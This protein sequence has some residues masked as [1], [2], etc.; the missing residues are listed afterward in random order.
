MLLFRSAMCRVY[1]EHCDVH[2]ECLGSQHPIE[3]I[4]Y[5]ENVANPVNEEIGT[6]IDMT[7]T[8]VADVVDLEDD[9]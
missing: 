4:K 2:L 3:D 5:H 9:D 1:G 7:P 6:V 8:E